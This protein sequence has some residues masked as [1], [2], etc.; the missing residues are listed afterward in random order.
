MIKILYKSDRFFF[1]PLC[2]YCGI[3]SVLADADWKDLSPEF[4]DKM[5]ENADELLFLLEY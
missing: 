5:H 2:P 1:T 3:D 4:L